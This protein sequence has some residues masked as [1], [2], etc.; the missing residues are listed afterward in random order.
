MGILRKLLHPDETTAPAD[1]QSGGQPRGGRSAL[2]SAT[3]SAPAVVVSEAVRSVIKKPVVTEKS[4][5]LNSQN[6]YVF[7]VAQSANKLQVSRAVEQVYGVKPVA[8]RVITVSGKTRVRGRIYGRTP[9]WKKAI[10]TLPAGKS[11]RVSE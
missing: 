5:L 9:D 3:S 2:M 11:I 10:V 4:S 8:V 6:Q 7:A 1:S